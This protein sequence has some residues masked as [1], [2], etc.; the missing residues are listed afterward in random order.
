MK[1]N[2]RSYQKGKRSRGGFVLV[3]L[4]VSMALFSVVVAIAVSGFITILR[5]QRQAAA[6]ISASSNL[7]L[8]IEQTAREIRNGHYFCDPPRGTACGSLSELVFVNESGQAV[9][10][11]L[12]NEAIERSIGSNASFDK[13]TD[14]NV[15]VKYLLF[16]V[17]GNGNDNLPPRVTISLGATHKDAAKQGNLVRL[18]TTVSARALDN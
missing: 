18:Q 8:T 17:E 9:A 4:L 15:L 10:Y 3:D 11:R 14:D 16:L 5:G 13:I 1:R 6:L 12:Q 2:L 7:S